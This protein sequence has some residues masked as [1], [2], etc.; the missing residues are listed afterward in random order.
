MTNK[1]CLFFVAKEKS[2]LIFRLRAVHFFMNI[3]LVK[4]VH[5]A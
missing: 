2:P 1:F 5:V 4:E 3:F